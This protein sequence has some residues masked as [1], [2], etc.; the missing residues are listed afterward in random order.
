MTL[1][2]PLALPGP[3]EG[4]ASA[5]PVLRARAAARPVPHLRHERALL[6]SGVPLVAGTDGVGLGPLA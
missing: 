1:L 4:A 6:R 2:D 3:D 5:A